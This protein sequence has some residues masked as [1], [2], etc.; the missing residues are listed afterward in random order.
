MRVLLSFRCMS[1]RAKEKMALNAVHT[2]VL[3]Y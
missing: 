3:V 1:K 2:M